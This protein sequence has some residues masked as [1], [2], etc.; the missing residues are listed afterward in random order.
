M[1]GRPD[2]TG[3]RPPEHITGYREDQQSPD[4]ADDV[5]AVCRQAE[6]ERAAEDPTVHACDAP[7]S[8]VLQQAG[9][10]AHRRALATRSFRPS[11]CARQ[12]GARAHRRALASRSSR[13]SRCA[14]RLSGWW[15]FGRSRPRRRRRLRSFSP[16]LVFECEDAADDRRHNTYRRF[17]E[18]EY[19]GRENP[20]QATATCDVSAF[21]PLAHCCARSVSGGV[22]VSTTDLKRPVVPAHSPS[23]ASRHP[24]RKLKC[25]AAPRYRRR[26][27]TTRT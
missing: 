16:S 8:L 2:E 24:R 18:F 13:R 10:R 12:V 3:A 25:C 9:A 21:G 17:H 11:R 4:Q 20:G 5:E 7:P 27:A 22:E 14:R 26:P 19:P 6:V 15:S 1:L 23:P